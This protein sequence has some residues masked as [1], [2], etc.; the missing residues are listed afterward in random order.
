MFWVDW[1]W[2]KDS[3]NHSP[4]A[5][6]PFL[7]KY[8]VFFP[9]VFLWH[10]II[11]CGGMDFFL[12]NRP[13]E[14]PP[15]PQKPHRQPP[16]TVDVRLPNRP[17]R[18]VGLRAHETVLPEPIG[19]ARPTCCLG[20]DPKQHCRAM[21][22]ELTAGGQVW[23]GLLETAFPV[24]AL[25]SLLTGK[26]RYTNGF[27]DWRRLHYRLAQYDVQL[28]HHTF[29]QPTQHQWQIRI[30]GVCQICISGA[31]MHLNSSKYCKMQLREFEFTPNIWTWEIWD[32]KVMFLCMFFFPFFSSKNEHLKTWFLGHF[33]AQNFYQALRLGFAPGCRCRL[34]GGFGAPLIQFPVHWTFLPLW[35][36][37]LAT[38]SGWVLL[39]RK[40]W[41]PADIKHLSTSERER[42]KMECISVQSLHPCLSGRLKVSR[43]CQWTN[44]KK[45]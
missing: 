6:D 10:F 16:T 40:R 21:P 3:R 8:A 38:I 30:Y 34:L 39:Q 15:A 36:Q 11:E 22:P 29:K 7:P 17:R 42:E 26:R 35:L 31:D 14:A 5:V 32:G 12:T 13:T 24:Q 1:W 18:R 45:N 25:Q 41:G 19:R 33:W 23:V 20:N 9:A 44:G 4:P 43:S 28:R 2:S 37:K 27:A